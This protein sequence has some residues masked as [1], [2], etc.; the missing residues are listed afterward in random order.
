MEWAE[1][2][3]PGLYLFRG[4]S[5]AE[6]KIQASAYRRLIDERDQTPTNLLEINKR[7]IDDARLQGHGQKNEDQLSDLEL[8]AEL[9]HYGAATCLIDFTHSAQVALWMACQRESKETAKSKVFNGK[10]FAVDI[11]DPNRFQKV[12][13]RL[14][15]KDIDCFFNGDEHERY[16]LYQWQPKQQNNRIIAQQS[17]FLFGGAQIESEAECT[18]LKNSKESILISL[19]KSGSIS[20]ARMFPD[21]DGFANLRAH[22]RLYVEHDALGYLQRGI[23]AHKER[24]L[25]EAIKHYTE[26]IQLKPDNP[27]LSRAYSNRGNAHEGKG[28]HD[29]AFEDYS[30]AI[31]INPDNADAYFYRGFVY[32]LKRNARKA[33]KDYDKA[34]ELNPEHIDAYVARAGVA[35]RDSELVIKDYSK[36]I[37]LNPHRSYAYR[38]RGL[39][40]EKR[41]EVDLAIKDYDKAIDLNSDSSLDYSHRARAYRANGKTDLAIEDYRRAIHLNP[42][43]IN[44]YYD[45]TV[46]FMCQRNWENAKDVLIAAQNR[47]LDIISLFSQYHQSIAHLEEEIGVELSEDITA[48]LR[49][50]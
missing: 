29:L 6:Y 17:V 4:V 18:I 43:Y 49:E 10:V 44:N 15:K 48:M 14:V 39:T 50:E 30:K 38:N 37:E 22:D 46:I 20:E 31:E 3:E 27:I 9:Q 24:K 19:E 25:D 47:E 7:I 36:A 26:S 42:Y 41:G 33:I 12:T 11:S 32:E 16:P 23:E 5:N 45:L 35:N 1:Q 13:S 40:Y 34:I 8:L 21:F 2:F 28:E